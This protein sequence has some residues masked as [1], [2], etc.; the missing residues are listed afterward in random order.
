MSFSPEYIEIC[1]E[2]L[3]FHAYHGVLPQE[4]KV[5]NEFIVD[6]MVRI[7]YDAAVA[8]DNLDATV[9]YARLHEIIS[10]EMNSPRKLMEAV[11]ASIAK[12]VSREWPGFID[13]RITI[14]KSTPPIAGTTGKAKI[15][16]V[17]KNFS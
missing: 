16:L 4:N 17:F 15:S 7:P 1:L 14:C 6:S 3:H 12:A 5:G 11:A 8:A 13:G 10:M 9:N 2:G